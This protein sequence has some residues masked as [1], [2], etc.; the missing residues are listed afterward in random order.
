ML[1]VLKGDLVMIKTILVP[2]D[3]SEGAEYA[4]P[5]AARIAH[6][7]SGALVLIRVVNIVTDYWPVAPYSTV[8]QGVI[9]GDLEEAT[10]YLETVAASPELAGLEVTL[11]ARHGVAPPIIQAAATE[12]QADLIVMCSHGRTGIAHVIMGSMAEKIARH[13]HIP[14]LIVREKGGLPQVN[15]AEMSQPL[16]VLV[17]LDGSAHAQA[18]LEPAAALLTAL[19]SPQ[20]K[21]AIHLVRVIEGQGSVGFD[22][23]PTP[24]D[25]KNGMQ[26]AQRE[27]SR[28]KHHLNRVTELI[29]EGSI[30]PEISRQQIAVTWSVAFDT[31]PARAIVR[32]AE[33]GEDAEGAGVFGGCGVIAIICFRRE[34]LAQE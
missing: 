12:Y 22:A 26:E 17:P 5:L 10:A 3:G 14:L 28:A 34:K 23:A 21:V 8:M 18:A 13:S 31:D 25:Q 19:A 7:T 33:T 24:S 32:V 20:Q 30:A 2:L 29:Q 16:R 27:L 15:P 6:H 11:T 1:L 4:L 9:D